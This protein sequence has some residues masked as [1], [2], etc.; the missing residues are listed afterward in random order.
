MLQNRNNSGS[1]TLVSA[2][3]DTTVQNC[4]PVGAAYSFLAEFP[5]EYFDMVGAFRL[6]FGFTFR[7]L[8]LHAL[9]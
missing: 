6:K 7:S 3:F 2:M 4:G 8:R 5:I 1:I 9:G